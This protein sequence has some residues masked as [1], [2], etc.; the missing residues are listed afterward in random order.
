MTGIAETLTS[1][2]KISTLLIP[3]FDIHFE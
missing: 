3:N 1:L 2:T